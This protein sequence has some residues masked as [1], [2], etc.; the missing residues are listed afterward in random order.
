MFHKQSIDLLITDHN[1]LYIRCVG[2]IRGNTVFIY[3][4]H[5]AHNYIALLVARS[6]RIDTI[7][8]IIL[9]HFNQ[10]LT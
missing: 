7:I 4:Y 6:T 9:A 1:I 3:M 10:T 5:V 8:I 2:N